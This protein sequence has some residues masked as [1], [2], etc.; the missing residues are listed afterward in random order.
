[1]VGEVI[2]KNAIISLP[3]NTK[4]IAPGH[5]LRAEI[6]DG[7]AGFFFVSTMIHNMFTSKSFKKDPEAYTRLRKLILS[8]TITLQMHCQ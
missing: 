8:W 4:V 5:E 1:V 7:L 2:N 6:I 3:N